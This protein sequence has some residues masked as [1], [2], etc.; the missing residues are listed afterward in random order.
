MR[1][2]SM[3]E[4]PLAGRSLVEA[5]AGTGKT[6]ALSTLFVRLLV[7]AHHTIDQILV[8]TFTE[9]ATLELKDRI[10][11]RLREALFAFESRLRTTVA[12]GGA[13]DPT[14]AE[15]ALAQPDPSEC[16][17][18]LQTALNAFDDAAIFTIH[19]FC[20]RVVKENAFLSGAPF[21]AELLKDTRALVEEVLLDYW[22]N[23]VSQASLAFVERLRK[24]GQQLTPHSL[25]SFANWVAQ[26]HGLRVLPALPP[27]VDPLELSAFQAA[28]DRARELYNEDQICE[29]LQGANLNG[30]R[31]RK[32]S[33]AA[34]CSELD[35]YFRAGVA[36]ATVPEHLERFTNAALR[37]ASKAMGAPSHPFFDACDELQAVALQFASQVDEHLL[38]FLRDL[39]TYIQT[40][41]PERKRARGVLSFDDL[42]TQLHDALLGSLGPALALSIQRR[43]PAALIDEFQDT[44]PLQYAIFERIYRGSA[45]SL[46]LIGDPKQAIYSFRGA[47]V[48]AYLSAAN[49]A[50]EERRYTM[51][52]NHRS[53]E[54][55]VQATNTLFLNSPAPFFIR[56]ITFPNVTAKQSGEPDL[57]LAAGLE[58]APL[59]FRFLQRPPSKNARGSAGGQRSFDYGF[60]QRELPALV[61][62]EVLDL[63]QSNTTLKGRRL[64]P[65]D[66]AVLTRTNAE[67]FECQR[68]LQH[69]RIPSVVQGDRSVYEYG[70][71]QELQLVLRAVLEPANSRAIRAALSTELLGQRAIDIYQLE[72]DDS[73]WDNWAERFRGY[74]QR[75]SSDGFVQMIRQLMQQCGVSERVLALVD[76]ERRM[77]NLLHLI[78]L[79]Q[80]ASTASH[81]GPS[82]LF[83]YLAQ[84]RTRE[85]AIKDNEQIRLESDE[86]AVV[87][88]TIHKAK[89]LEY[90]IVIC[91]TLFSGMLVHPGDRHTIR[92]HD[93]EAQGRLTL[94]LGTA[95]V[96]RHQ[97]WMREEAMAENLRLLYV[98]LT[99]ARH[100]TVVYWGAFREFETSAL[101]Y[102]L[103]SAQFLS[104]GRVPSVQLCKG[105][106]EH[107]SDESLLG[108]L[109]ELQ[110]E[111]PAI[112]VSVVTPQELERLEDDT[113]VYA[114]PV[115]STEL[116][117]RSM[118]RT[119]RQWARTAS[120]TELSA[121][122]AGHGAK[123]D[124]GRDTDEGT[125]IPVLARPA[126]TEACLLA[127]FPG[128]AQ[129]GNLFH[130][131]LEHIDFEHQDH[132]VRIQQALAAY[133][134]PDN[135][136]ASGAPL[137][138]GEL[139]M[140]VQDSINDFLD[141]PL[142][143]DA[144]SADAPSLNLRKV[145]T[146]A[147][148]NEMEFCVP[149]AL[150][151]N[152]SP[153]DARSI[154]SVFQRHPSDAVPG[155]Y[156]E[157]L[158]RLSFLPL[159]GY[160]KGF[161]D[162]VF[163]HAGKWYVVDYKTNN[164]GQTY[165]DYALSALQRAMGHS[166]YFLQYH[167]YALAL[168]RY[169][170][171]R[172]RGY[173]YEA[174][175][176]G[177]YYLFLRG[178]APRF[179]PEYGVF[180]EKPPIGRI[181]A[182]SQLFQADPAKP[183]GAAVGG[184]KRGAATP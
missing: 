179:G 155:D 3:L 121:G 116:V 141:T 158:L 171:Y 149:A 96:E 176:G 14:L 85:F 104:A 73:A 57:K 143:A 119:L 180:F 113:S 122:D 125:T 148:L 79:L 27:E 127:R 46:F 103:H 115:P 38:R 164:L 66:F 172:L 151:S 84:Q 4:A 132:A 159:S 131:L 77:T 15:L 48:F 156:V 123:R 29:L 44:D 76:G 146:A 105:D 81:L 129:T 110:A 111:C 114:R 78:E 133:G 101:G 11:R 41:I 74:N 161:I 89:G 10:R 24:P 94:D 56:D 45:H 18:R 83:Q 2:F 145:T 5:S 52:V 65:K 59:Q 69:L 50:D 9:A 64:I 72:S 67:A 154:A 23:H 12:T 106:L 28:F 91:P 162:L 138:A 49:S 109:L 1:T 183:P 62:R 117:C 35:S 102:L 170:K 7:E 33:I 99:R 31:Y 144:S 184:S 140:L 173:S 8:V 107:R 40:S 130:E 165:G 178:M 61:A 136:P 13:V 51:A 182:L 98:A 167:L 19:G 6:Y 97:Q 20:H 90:P 36:L 43:F 22:S 163:V 166:H 124:D 92:F 177:V 150:S 142:V 39:V 157:E 71:A 42:L 169:L 37:A 135:Q 60:K 68:A 63:L 100:R 134:Y 108:R 118:K 93:P 17:A 34:W 112:G 139:Q 153:I 168:H 16:I 175:F 95:D 47:D 147:R 53:D 174:H 21:Q 86:D 70:E 82:G 152:T 26:T 80:T 128:G 58:K 32:A 137:S 88:T 126:S 87:L 54:A 25:R 30:N 120:F 75:W 160:L 55:L 181:E